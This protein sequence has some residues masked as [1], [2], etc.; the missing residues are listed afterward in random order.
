MSGCFTKS[1]LEVREL[2]KSFSGLEV[3]RGVSTNVRT[4]EVR[5][6][7][8][9]NGAGKTTFINTLTGVYPPSAG[10]VIL[11]GQEITGLPAFKIARRGLIRT[12]QIASLFLDLTVLENVAVASRAA[13]HFCRTSNR[14]DGN[15]TDES[16]E[17]LK[18]VEIAHLAASRAGD[19]SHG[20]QRL[21]EVAIALAVKP[22]VLLLDEPTAGMSPA[23]TR[24]FVELLNGRLRGL[25]TI[26]L[27]EHDMQ[28]VMNTADTISVLALG[29]I[30]AEGS[31]TEVKADANVQEAYLGSAYA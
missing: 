19:V 20:D 13:E 5:A 4:G 12:C 27:V 22:S 24:H 2:R 25:Y 16:Q 28:V 14:V 30:I 26:V 1:L 17:V 18:T 29:K 6:L 3:L 21:L 11:C 15:T 23:E 7:I 31:P 10:A 8:G 9:P